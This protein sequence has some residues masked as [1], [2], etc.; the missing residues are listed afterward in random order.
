ME[1]VLDT[2]PHESPNRN[3]LVVSDTISMD[4]ATVT[5]SEVLQLPDK[6]SFI[7]IVR[8]LSRNGMKP[9][10]PFL[11]LL[12]QRPRALKLVFMFFASSSLIAYTSVFFILSL[13][14]KSTNMN[15]FER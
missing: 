7:S 9:D 4:S 13:P 14:A 11:S 2:L 3:E 12:I 15:L 5:I 10:P 1:V 8:A 6:H